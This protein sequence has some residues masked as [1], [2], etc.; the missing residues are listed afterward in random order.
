M[1]TPLR[2]RLP[3]PSPGNLVPLPGMLDTLVVRLTDTGEVWVESLDTGGRAPF[4]RGLDRLSLAAPGPGGGTEVALTG[5]ERG[6]LGRVAERF[7][8][9]RGAALE[10]NPGEQA[11]VAAD[12][13]ADGI[14]DCLDLLV[15]FPHCPRA[16]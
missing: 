13:V 14:P 10:G 3:V 2:Y 11:R 16:A 7:E 4:A 6:A 9:W 15:R 5:E 12:L 8:A 1:S